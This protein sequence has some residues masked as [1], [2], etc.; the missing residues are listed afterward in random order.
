MNSLK[1]CRKIEF[2][3]TIAYYK[4][5]WKFNIKLAY[6]DIISII[7]ADYMQFELNLTD[8]EFVYFIKMVLA[9]IGSYLVGRGIADCKNI[10]E[11]PKK[12]KLIEQ[13]L[14]EKGIEISFDKDCVFLL[15]KADK[16][17][18]QLYVED[19]VFECTKDS[20]V[21]TCPDNNVDV[22]EEINKVLK[23]KK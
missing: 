22:T 19:K 13:K 18:A 7:I 16:L 23:Y 11:A 17:T 15:K 8:D 4:K 21:Y 20:I 10:K 1:K 3:D 9:A 2:I 6:S 12:I 14:K 5:E